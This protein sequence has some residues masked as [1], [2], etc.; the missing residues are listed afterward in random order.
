M[1]FIKKISLILLAFLLIILGLFMFLFGTNTGSKLIFEGITYYIPGLTF[2]SVSGCWG[3][4]N[5]MNLKYNLSTGIIKIDELYLSMNLKY[6]LFKQINFEHLF[7][8]NVFINVQNFKSKKSEIKNDQQIMTNYLFSTVYPIVLKNIVLNNTHIVLNH[9]EFQFKKINTGIIFQN[10]LLKILPTYI[11][12]G[13]ILHKF[14]TDFIK[15][16][17]NI[18]AIRTSLFLKDE[19]SLQHRFKSFVAMMLKIIS[20]PQYNFPIKLI[21]TDI[22][23]INLNIYD[24]Y[25]TKYD[26]INYFQFRAC[27]NANIVDMQFDIDLPNGRIKAIANLVLCNHYPINLVCDYTQHDT[28]KV[29]SNHELDKNLKKINLTVTGT[30]T[31]ELCI[32]FD[33]L[34][35]VSV[36]RILFKIQLKSRNIPID[37]LIIFKK[38]PIYL[39]EKKICILNKMN[40]R[41]I[42]K[43]YDNYRIDMQ[44]E[45]NCL[46]MS[47]VRIVL[48]AQGNTYHCKISQLKLEVLHGYRHINEGIS[49][50]KSINWNNIFLFDSSDFFK[51]YFQ[52]LPIE[53]SGKII[54][55]GY[56]SKDSWRLSVPQFQ[57][58][59]IINNSPIILNGE[60]YIN[61]HGE[62]EIPIFFI[63]WGSNLLEIKGGIKNNCVFD[64]DVKFKKINCANFLSKLNGSLY[65]FCKLHGPVKSPVLSLEIHINDL[66]WTDA[67]I[68]ISS[69]LIDGKISFNNLI[70]NYFVL[71]MNQIKYKKLLLY[72]LCIRGSGNIETHCINFEINDNNLSGIFNLLGQFNLENK[73]WSSQIIK[74]NIVTPMGT[75]KLTQDLMFVYQ[76][77]SREVIVKSHSWENDHCQFTFSD[78]FQKKFFEQINVICKKFGISVLDRMPINIMHIHN[79]HVSFKNFYWI[80]GHKM[81]PQGMILISGSKLFFECVCNYSV[82]D[83]I[84]IDNMLMKLTS[85]QRGCSGNWSVCQ[86]NNQS[87]GDF[88]ITN[89]FDIPKVI[90]KVC[91]KEASLI[92]IFKFLLTPPFSIEELLSVNIDFIGCL[93]APKI[94]GVVQY[95]YKT[96]DNSN[97]LFFINNSSVQI[98]FS[99]DDAKVFGTITTNLGQQLSLDGHLTQFNSIHNTGCL[100]LNI[101][102]NQVSI[103]IL[104]NI[105]ITISPNIIC[106]ITTSKIDISGDVEIPSA[107]IKI[108]KL[109]K[110]IIKTSSEEVILDNNL[111]SISKKPENYSICITSNLML[112]LGNDVFFNG[113]GLHTKL[114]GNLQIVY[115]NS[116]LTLIGYINMFSGF[117]EKY[118]Q[119]LKIKKGQ[120]LFPGAINQV[121]LDIEAVR[122]STFVLSDVQ[123]AITVGVRVT[124]MIDQLRWDFFS[125]SILLSQQEIA[126]YLLNGDNLILSDVY[127]TNTITSLLIGVGMQRYEKFIKKI[128]RFL[129]VRDLKINTQSLGNPSLI[130]LSGYIA[131]G[132]QIKYGIS[133]FDL[134]TTV[135]IRYC[136]WPYLY[137]EAYSGDLGQGVD[138]LYQ[139]H[140]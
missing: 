42:G 138:L 101:T 20:K 43:L 130:A 117:F 128:G 109:S 78:D 89:L 80:I 41:I 72:Q 81:M 121:Y 132:L 12:E 31:D 39:S 7:L 114:K 102:G 16:K 32:S 21:L 50:G 112:N 47:K 135:T 71:K 120:L 115:N 66:M 30:I 125:N 119:N 126:S 61:S 8:K 103:H 95:A 56:V 116:D 26:V 62:L 84:V 100:L 137:L 22:Q 90:G 48:N 73:T 134:L 106:T 13:E 108:Q 36:V 131:P 69:I 85:D 92:P 40:F 139:I 129:G 25:Q 24:F 55:K 18:E 74:T 57:F 76:H 2:G 96:I 75:W 133:I 10:N 37:L 9:C 68:S 70:K 1:I 64:I 6:I 123:D 63:K 34:N 58:Y 136:I 82:I 60:I 33:F 59:G 17:L 45:L 83:S 118:G 46:N 5:I 29:Y 110:S 98:I 15:K 107:N 67:S 91:I 99:G 97:K 35:L 11:V 23:G 88:C 27:W 52:L 53:L 124:G 3:K 105:C 54:T 28:S 140:S 14:S 113:F 127:D 122:N 87:Y 65:G 38:I 19:F 111:N 104:D 77:L 49:Y 51:K 79:L 93:Y 44:S 94:Y 4:F 86:N